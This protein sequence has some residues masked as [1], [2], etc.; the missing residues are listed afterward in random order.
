MRQYFGVANAVVVAHPDDEVLWCGGFLWRYR[1]VG[2]DVIC[3][4]IPRIDPVRAWRFVAACRALG[5]SPLLLPFTESPPDAPLRHLEHLEGL[6]DY[7]CLVTHGEKGEYGHLHHCQVHQHVL[8]AAAGNVLTFGGDMALDLNEEEVAAKLYALKRYDHAAPY[9]GG[10]P[11]KWQALLHR[12]RD[13][14]GI[15]FE[16]E[17]FTLARAA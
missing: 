12:Y 3:C 8:S 5:A 14:E 7:D 16:R 11:P 10:N 2:W 13:V 15:P 17:S 6:R 9:L 1:D 4:S